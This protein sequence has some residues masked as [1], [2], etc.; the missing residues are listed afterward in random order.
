MTQSSGNLDKE[1]THRIQSGWNNWRKVTGVACDRRVPIRLKGKVYKTVVRPALTYGL[2]TAPIKKNEEKKLDVAEMKMLRWMSG[3]TRSDRIRSEYIR[4]TL[5]VTEAS[6]N[7]QEGRLCW[8]DILREERK[9]IWQ[10]KQW[11][12]RYPEID[13]EEDLKQGGRTRLQKI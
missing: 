13:D 6:K 3:V 8:Q 9:D 2:E 4:G 11:K 7:V 1:V 10:E 5:K 12:W